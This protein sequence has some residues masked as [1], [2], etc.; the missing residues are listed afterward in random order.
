VR[1]GVI[2]LVTFASDM[3]YLLI[4]IILKG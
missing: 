3:M 1:V 4:E 2:V